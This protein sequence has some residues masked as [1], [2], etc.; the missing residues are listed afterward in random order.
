MQ[1]R[2]AGHAASDMRPSTSGVTPIHRDTLM[3]G[4]LND[5]RHHHGGIVTAADLTGPRSRLEAHVYGGLGPELLLGHRCLL[6]N[7]EVSAIEAAHRGYR[8]LGPARYDHRRGWGSESWLLLN[9]GR[10]RVILPQGH[11]IHD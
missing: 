6:L 1:L 2:S 3:H 8:R 9:S 5:L 4:L 7:R 11:L 10:E